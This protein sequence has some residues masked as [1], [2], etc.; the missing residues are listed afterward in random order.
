MS[1]ILRSIGLLGSSVVLSSFSTLLPIRVLR[2]SNW[3]LGSGLGTSG[4]LPCNTSLI[5]VVTSSPE[6]VF[7][8]LKSNSGINSSH[9][10]A[11]FI[12]CLLSSSL[13]ALSIG[14]YPILNQLVLKCLLYL[15]EYSYYLSYLQYNQYP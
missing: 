11:A 2:L 6:V 7:L 10:L 4:S 12:I 5:G 3:N 8:T 9:A 15:K 13:T 14:I 1:G